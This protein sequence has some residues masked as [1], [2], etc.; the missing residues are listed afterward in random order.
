MLRVGITGGIGAGKTTVCK[1][2]EQLGVPVYYAD[3]RAKTLMYRDLPLKTAIKELL[4]SEA[5]HR[6]GRPNRGYIA[7]K[8]F[9]DADLLQKLN[10]LVHPAVE[11]DA[12]EWYSQ[13]TALPYALYEAALLVENGTYRHYDKLISVT[14]PEGVRIQRVVQRDGSSVEQVT[15]RL[16]HQLPQAKKDSLADYVINNVDQASLV[17]QVAAVHKALLAVAS[18]S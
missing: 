13:Y 5:Y 15:A 9:S 7:A 12:H 2:F 8:V 11:A 4:G 18:D 14:A 3:I 16:Q 6:N 17:A 10:A 1:L